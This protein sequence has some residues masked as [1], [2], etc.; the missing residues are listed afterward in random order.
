MKAS[1]EAIKALIDGAVTALESSAARTGSVLPEDI[2]ERT[3][4]LIVTSK[5]P[6]ESE[7]AIRQLRIG[8][9]TEL[10]VQ[11]D[12]LVAE[13][14]SEISGV[15][16]RT[17]RQEAIRAW[18][19][20]LLS[21]SFELFWGTL[22]SLARIPEQVDPKA[23][24][25]YL[26]MNEDLGL[27]LIE[28]VRK[29]ADGDKVRQKINCQI[30]SGGVQCREPVKDFRGASVPTPLPLFKRFADLCEQEDTKHPVFNTLHDDLN[31]L[32]RVATN[33]R[34]SCYPIASVLDRFEYLCNL[35][36]IGDRILAA[37]NGY[38]PMLFDKGK[39]TLLPSS[40]E[41]EIIRYALGEI[42]VGCDNAQ[43]EQE[44]QRIVFLT[45]VQRDGKRI[46]VDKIMAKVRE[47]CPKTI[48]IIDGAQDHVLYPEADCVLYGKRM[49][50]TGTGM[51]M[52]S[53]TQFG[54][55]FREAFRLKRGYR[56]EDIARTFAAFRCETAPY[57][58]ANHWSDLM[59]SKDLWNFQG[60]GT[61]IDVQCGRIGDFVRAHPELDEHFVVQVSQEP[62]DETWKSSRIVTFRQKLNSNLNLEGFC[63]AMQ[64]QGF[65]INWFSLELVPEFQRLL[66]MSEQPS[67]RD[68]CKTFFAAIMGFQHRN[69]DYIVNEMLVLPEVY[70]G[71]DLPYGAETCY[72]QQVQH[73]KDSAK[74][75][76]CIRILIDNRMI[77]DDID[78]L[79]EA[80]AQTAH[81]F[82][83]PN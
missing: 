65:Q 75:Q 15:E 7:A 37:N 45:S 34:F 2:T 71:V 66:E 42:T 41:D 32:C 73:L 24:Q 83:P 74:R 82:S 57:H 19:N 14:L 31:Q 23:L 47:R 48:F 12:T 33:G 20:D 60:R 6:E 53:D 54:R 22:E 17:E 80:M 55:K 64:V 50:G 68:N 81:S 38:V 16:D 52:F 51:I 78:G 69:F 29:H 44:A 62:T 1:G 4:N 36:G 43:D 5:L 39:F 40:T 8:F 3:D 67:G 59:K 56:V 18:I 72:R 11:L 49:G 10:L 13:Q 58:F 63:N 27:T 76:R 61:Y 25:K 79:L 70:N 35:P 30:D 28:V 26:E 9:R 21:S 77:P 46:N